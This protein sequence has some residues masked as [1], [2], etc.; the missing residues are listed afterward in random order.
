MDGNQKEALDHLPVY[1][2]ERTMFKTKLKNQRGET[3]EEWF[4]TR[5]LRLGMSS[6][7]CNACMRVKCALS[8]YL[9]KGVADAC[10]YCNKI[11]RR[12][13]FTKLIEDGVHD[14]Q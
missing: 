3:I 4:F 2:T 12:D 14:D 11:I 10:P 6:Y 7:I 1:Y 8:T 5:D 9:L 13:S